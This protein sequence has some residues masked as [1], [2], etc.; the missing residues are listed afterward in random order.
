MKF[1]KPKLR[2]PVQVRQP[3]RVST[4]AGTDLKSNLGQAF[5]IHTGKLFRVQSPAV[6]LSLK[7]QTQP[8]R[9]TANDW[10]RRFF[11]RRMH[12]SLLFRIGAFTAKEARDS[13]KYRKNPRNASKPGT[14]P[15][16]HKPGSRRW[17]R[18]IQFG[19]YNGGVIVGSVY[20]HNK[21]NTNL[22]VPEAQEHGGNKII[23]FRQVTG[24]VGKRK[25]SG[26]VRSQRELEAIRR[27]I[28][29]REILTQSRK[30]VAKYKKRS[31]ME[32][33]LLRVKQKNSKL[34]KGLR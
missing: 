24:K 9:M 6:S 31:F 33:A 23:S 16:A 1:Y 32:P 27:K 34:F 5:P 15:H 2:S 25:E 26:R 22:T 12:N 13:I 29:S 19:Y 30:I 14:P 8:L 7:L 17:F 18:M 4:Q 11:P 3:V 28:G 21:G 20:F 10:K